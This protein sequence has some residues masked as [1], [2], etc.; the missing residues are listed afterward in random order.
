MNK[1]LIPWRKKNQ[2]VQRIND[3]YDPFEELHQQMNSLFDSFSPGWGLDRLP[4]LRS[5]F[6]ALDSFSPNFDV[7]ETDDDITITAELPGMDEKDIQVSVDDS[8]LTIS[9]EKKQE[10]EEK[11]KDY[12]FSERSY[13]Q[14]RRTISLP[15]TIDKDS[16]KAS[17]KKGVLSVELPKREEQN[18]EQKTIEIQTE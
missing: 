17:F 18:K 10:R 9:G 13:G 3:A 4:G 5:R 14:F 11:K 12:H 1:S 7:A 2:S 16:V 8:T 6:E 15:A